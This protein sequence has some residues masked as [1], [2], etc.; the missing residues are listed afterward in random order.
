MNFVFFTRVKYALCTIYSCVNLSE[1]LGDAVLIPLSISSQ[2]SSPI[3]PVSCSH[4]T[5]AFCAMVADLCFLR[6]KYKFNMSLEGSSP[7]ITL[8][9]GGESATSS[10]LGNCVLIAC[11]S[12]RYLK[13]SEL[14]SVY[15][16]LSV[17]NG[18]SLAL[19]TT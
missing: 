10:K 13:A 6:G 1:S 2:S 8:N 7:I 4:F 9:T 17:W 3:W 5:F 19:D 18:L 11:W 16:S 12:C 14:G 15:S